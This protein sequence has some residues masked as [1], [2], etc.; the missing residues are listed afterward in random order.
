[1]FVPFSSNA[2]ANTQTDAK[3][4]MIYVTDFI[5]LTDKVAPD[6]V[7]GAIRIKLETVNPDA[8]EIYLLHVE[9]AYTANRLGRP[10]S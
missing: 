6:D 9:V 8:T 5:N 7:F 4:G 1:M 3:P 2:I 10:L